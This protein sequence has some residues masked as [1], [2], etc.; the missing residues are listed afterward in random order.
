MTWAQF[1]GESERLADEAYLAMRAGDAARARSLY[2]QAADWETRALETVTAD[3]PRTLGVTAVSAVALR[4]KSGAREATER[5]GRQLLRNR[6]LPRFAVAQIEDMVSEVAAPK[7]V[8]GPGPKFALDAHEALDAAAPAND[9][10][11]ILAARIAPAR[12]AAL[13]LLAA[14][15]E[16]DEQ[17]L[18]R[19]SEDYLGEIGKAAGIDWGLVYG[20]GVFLENAAEAA[21]RAMKDRLIPP[22][23]ETARAALEELLARHGELMLASAEGEAMQREADALRLT[24][25]AMASLREDTLALADALAPLATAPAHRRL[26]RAARWFGIGRSPRRSAEFGLAAFANAAA[27]LV[28]GAASAPAGAFVRAHAER[29]RRLAASTRR[30]RAA[31]PWIDLVAQG[32]GA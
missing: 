25:D 24:R 18:R 30:L 12:Q 11:K 16:D 32:E 23:T 13:A 15:S 3:K 6:E 14:L 20:Y 7:L 2:A 1:H 4:Y 9:N 21:R 10:S 17:D 5:L 27:E 8:Q 29:L 28:N 19:D 26:A 31:R 22:L